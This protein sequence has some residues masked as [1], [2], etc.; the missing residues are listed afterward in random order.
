[1]E[2]APNF[3]HFTGQARRAILL[4]YQESQRFDLDY[5]ASEQLLAGLVREGSAE[6]IRVFTDQ[7][8]PVDEVLEKVEG[9]LAT[10]GDA[11]AATE[12]FLTP[13]ARHALDDAIQF[14]RQSPDGQAGPGEILQS[15]LSDSEGA[16]HPLLDDLG[17]DVERGL[18]VLAERSS[19]VNR[20]LLVQSSPTTGGGPR[21]DPTPQQLAQ[22]FAGQ[23]PHADIRGSELAP[24]LQAGVAET[25]YQLFLTQLMLAITMGAASGYILYDSVDG[26]A[27]AAVFLALVACFRNSVLGVIAGAGLGGMLAQQIQP[28]GRLFDTPIEAL[29]P[30]TVIGGFIGSFLGNFWRRVCPSYLRPSTTHQKP[31]GVV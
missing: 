25:D 30:M 26:M 11:S 19:A 5:L 8:I 15:L 24:A 17:F 6:V 1:M 21:V 13:R 12:I 29:V 23:S 3:E 10:S 4:A 28:G 27:G 18:R 7:S 16:I 9:S 20:D 22:L 31:P 14:A 2:S